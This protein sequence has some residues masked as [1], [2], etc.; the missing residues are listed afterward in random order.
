MTQYS[1]RSSAD[2]QAACDAAQAV[3]EILVYGGRFTEASKLTRKKGFAHRPIVI[4]AADDQWISG[5]RT[6]SHGCRR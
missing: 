3:D 5:G 6:G 4:R 2:L 1:V